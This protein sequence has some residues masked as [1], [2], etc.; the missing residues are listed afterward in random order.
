VLADVAAPYCEGGQAVPPEAFDGAPAVIADLAEDHRLALIC[1]TG[2]SP[3]VVLRNTLRRAG[4]L[5]YFT[6]TVFSDELGWRK[7]HPAAFAAATAGLGLRPAECVHV[8]D[9]PWTDGHG[10]KA[11]GLYA[12]L[13]VGGEH[14]RRPVR[15][16]HDLSAMC[17]D[18]TVPNLRALPAAIRSL[19]APLPTPCACP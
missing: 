6:T 11:A 13:L 2:S 8:G 18:A 15:S 19:T 17:P 4:L 3:G 10:A 1:N 12:I 5:D 9:D 7:P 16:I 14:G